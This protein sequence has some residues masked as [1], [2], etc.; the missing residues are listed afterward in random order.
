MIF[1]SKYRFMNLFHLRMLIKHFRDTNIL[2]V[3]EYQFN[4]H[5]EPD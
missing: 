2:T 4:L 1:N 5:K 3:Q